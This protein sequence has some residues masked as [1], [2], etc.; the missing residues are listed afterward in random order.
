MVERPI[1]I[2]LSELAL[3]VTERGNVGLRLAK[4]HPSLGFDPEMV[5]ATELSPTEARQLA[6]RLVRKADEAEDGPALH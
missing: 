6:Q 2:Q 3:T 1:F 5:F 4:P